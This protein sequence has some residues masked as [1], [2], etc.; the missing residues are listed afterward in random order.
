MERLRSVGAIIGNELYSILVDRNALLIMLAAPLALACIIGLAFSGI[1]SGEMGFDPIPIAVVNLD[2]A[3]EV[4]GRRVALGEQFV[5]A[6][7]P[8]DDA[9]P[10]ERAENGLWQIVAA[11]TM[12]DADAARA[13]VLSGDLVAALVIPAD[14]SA[15]ISVSNALSQS[16][17]S[18]MR[19]E[20]F[21]DPGSGDLADIAES[22]VN[23]IGNRIATGNAAISSAIGAL[24]ISSETNPQLA[25]K[26]ATA[27]DGADVFDPDNFVEILADGGALP[28]DRETFSGQA[29]TFSP[30]ALFG[31]SQ[32]IFFM[33][34]TAMATS[35]EFLRDKRNGILARL[36]STPNPISTIV[37]GKIGAAV[38]TCATQVLLLLTALTL[39]SAVATGAFTMI[40]GTNVAGLLA[41]I[42]TVS[43]AAAGLAMCVASLARTP[44]QAQAI[45]GVIAIGMGLLGGAFFNVQNAGVVSFLSRMTINYWA[46]DAI[47]RLS[48]GDN[49]IWR[50]LG[51]LSL[52]G[53]VTLT[54]A[55][56]RFNRTL[57][58]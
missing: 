38:V 24:L 3:R 28:I 6:L 40:F 43:L 52:I 23:G 37:M 50:N 27:G 13:L 57:E 8:P 30:F 9:T 44:E 26:L 42:V 18:A 4:G 33:L 41:V 25:A 19:A 7:V 17:P 32:A 55:F 1:A 46:V 35:A 48:M 53:A 29:A 56:T 10:E 16:A 21:T 45:N 34:F 58:A 36:L 22:V 12:T 39:I 49:D 47:N 11:R 51:V 2:E 14:F 31:A 54:V 15:V 5:G 20:L